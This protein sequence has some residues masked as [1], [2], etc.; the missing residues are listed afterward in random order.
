VRIG[1]AASRVQLGLVAVVAL[2]LTACGGG[3]PAG[4]GEETG[5]PAASQAVSGLPSL[6]P[7]ASP[8]V[9]VLYEGEF[10]A[11]GSLAELEGAQGEGSWQVRLSTDFVQ[12]IRPGLEDVSAF[13][14]N[15]EYYQQGMR[16]QAGPL[17]VT[18]ASSA[19]PTPTGET[20]PYT[21]SV[22]F[23]DFT[24]EGCARRGLAE[25]G[26]ELTWAVDLDAL[27]PAIDACLAGGGAQRPVVTLASVLPPSPDG[28]VL[29]SVR[30]RDAT[31]MRRECFATPDGTQV[32]STDVLAD[33]DV[34]VGEGEAE[35]SR[36][37]GAAPGQRRCRT[38]EAVTGADGAALGWVARR[39]C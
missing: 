4:T 11:F 12:L 32:I 30:M 39:T 36:A 13:T 16:A 1:S 25:P 37:P 27:I 34:R 10:E 18:I 2:A 3:E 24:Y 29:V 23:E 15:R 19:C 35:F 7:A 31:R 21:A 28:Q 14:V 5:G 38:A 33:A 17:V 9:R 20:L 26:E 8:D 22:L 6:G